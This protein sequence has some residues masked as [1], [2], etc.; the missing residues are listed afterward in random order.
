MRLPEVPGIDKD[1]IE[2]CHNT[3]LNLCCAL[4][5]SFI[6]LILPGVGTFCAGLCAKKRESRIACLACGFLQ[7]ILVEVVIGIIWAWYTSVRFIGNAAESVD[8]SFKT[9]TKKEQK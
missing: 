2:E 1:L 4:F 3:N 6:N 7:V 8:C 5:V 9:K